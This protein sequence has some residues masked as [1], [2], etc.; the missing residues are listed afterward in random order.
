[1]I[2]PV[3]TYGQ[4]ILRERAAPVTEDSPVL[5][6]L[7]DDMIETMHGASGVG[8][9]ANQVGHPVRLFVA[10]LSPY[11]DELLEE[12][13]EVPEWGRGPVAFINPEVVEA[14]EESAVEIEEGCLSIPDVREYVVRPDRLRVRYLDRR[15]QPHEIP[16]LGMLARVF[17]HE[18]D[19]LDG[20][21]F[22]DHLSALKRRL[23]QRRLREM[24]AGKVEADYLLYPPH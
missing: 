3:Y 6:R 10:D 24:A 23:L 14:D 21:L 20:V 17:Q 9:A 7:I 19:H 1:M 4:P 18:L 13:G 22:V 11:E 5:Q 12:F 15:F 2:L 8:L 16:A